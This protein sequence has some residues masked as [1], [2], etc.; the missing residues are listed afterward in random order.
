L[1]IVCFRYRPAGADDQALNPLNQ[2]IVVGLQRSGVA[3]LS[4]TW[5]DGRFAIRV[6]ITNHRS[7]I[8]DFDTLVGEVVRQGR[9]LR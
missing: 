3:A 4:H 5:I 2:S 6:S 7:R 9:T 8:E 1:N